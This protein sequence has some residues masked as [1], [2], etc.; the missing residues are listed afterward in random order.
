MAC[1]RLTLAAGDVLYMPKGL[2][3]YATAT[4]QG[5]STHLTI[6]LERDRVL[7]KRL[8]PAARDMALTTA[9]T[10]P[11]M[12][13]Q[14]RPILDAALNAS[15]GTAAGIAWLSPLP[16]WTVGARAR[17]S[18]DGALKDPCIAVV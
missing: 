17:A 7:W 14:L 2:V 12:R 9:I 6:G 15:E 8:W 4:A 3:H 18:G 5:I 11:R 10:E 1:T 16:L 13:A